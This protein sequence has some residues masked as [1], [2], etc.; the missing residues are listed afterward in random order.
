MRRGTVPVKYAYYSN[1]GT[2]FKR[3]SSY[4]E[5]HHEGHHFSLLPGE[6]LSVLLIEFVLV[7]DVNSNDGYTPLKKLIMTLCVSHGRLMQQ[8]TLSVTPAATTFT[9][10]TNTLT[11]NLK[12]SIKTF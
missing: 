9:C 2:H 8:Q 12:Y 4:N 1:K 6:K 10:I 7:S 5:S 3:I 11:S